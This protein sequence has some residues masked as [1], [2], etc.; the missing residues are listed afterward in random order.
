MNLILSLA[1]LLML[2]PPISA[3]DEV[4]TLTNKTNKVEN[5]IWSLEEDYISSYGK[6]NHGKILSLWHCA[7]SIAHPSQK[8]D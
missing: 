5:K 8:Y 6:A 3:Q 4:I 2:V 1:I 7:Y